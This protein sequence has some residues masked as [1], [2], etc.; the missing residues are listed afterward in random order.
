MIEFKVGDVVEY[1]T[2]MGR[3]RRV[4]V[5]F[6][7]TE[8]GHPVFDGVEVGTGAKVWGWKDSVTKVVSR[9]GW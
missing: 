1:V 2:I 3:T 6:F 8:E 9:K 5:T 7:G 4:R